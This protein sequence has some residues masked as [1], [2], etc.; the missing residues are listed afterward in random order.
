[1]KFF[2]EIPERHFGFTGVISDLLLDEL[3]N[4]DDLPNNE[5]IGKNP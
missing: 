1:M 2:D 5:Q 3:D 4:L